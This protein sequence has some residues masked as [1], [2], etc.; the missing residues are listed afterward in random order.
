[1]GKVPT[2]TRTTKSGEVAKRTTKDGKPVGY[3]AGR[4]TWGSIKEVHVR[5]KAKGDGTTT[6]GDTRY[7]PSYLR[8]APGDPEQG[9]RV[10][11]AGS[12]KHRWEAEAWLDAQSEATLRGTINPEA[13]AAEAAA[14]ALPP[15][16][17]GRYAEH[18]I[19]TNHDLKPSTAQGYRY[20]VKGPL[21]TF[22]DID[23]EA[24]RPE[25][26]DV[27]FVDAKERA[28]TRAARSYAL[29]SSILGHAVESGR[30]ERNP[31]NVK[32]ARQSKTGKRVEWPTDV[33]LQIIEAS[34][35]A[36]YSFM[37]TFAAWSALRWG[38][39]TELRRGDIEFMTAPDREGTPR[40][41]PIVHVT[42]AVTQIPGQGFV[43][44]TPKSARGVRTL[45][46]RPTLTAP[47]RERLS[48]MDVRDDALV[49]PSP[50]DPARHL[51]NGQFYPAWNAA[52]GTAG[53]PDLPFHALRHFGGTKYARTGATTREIMDF[54]GHNDVQTTMIYQESADRERAAE[55]A[56]QMA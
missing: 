34:I 13:L 27:W 43:I 9:V 55:L 45:I 23:V 14:K 53:R 10:Y 28:A 7:Q 18:W 12:F 39:L 56:L 46:L 35:D 44:G 48:S 29:L 37:V 11:G 30:I 52:R 17:F 6:K 54:M 32:R 40:E 5:R 25:M 41:L 8:K 2:V 15:M 42:R 3:R 36:Q 47:L 16:T 33:E 24:I 4:R 1:M 22:A 51:G 31:A 38:E 20:L 50:K 19:R 21:A 26:I 49:F